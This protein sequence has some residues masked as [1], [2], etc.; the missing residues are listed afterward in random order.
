MDT[1]AF[2]LN[3]AKVALKFY[4]RTTYFRSCPVSLNRAKVAL[5]SIW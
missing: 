3:R 5:K 4:K 1:L 2:S